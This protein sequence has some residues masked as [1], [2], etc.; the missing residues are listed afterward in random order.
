MEYPSLDRRRQIALPMRLAP[1]VT[2]TVP[3]AM[4][5]RRQHLILPVVSAHA[6]RSCIA[7]WLM[8]VLHPTVRWHLASLPSTGIQ[9]LQE[10]VEESPD[11]V[12]LSE[13]RRCESGC[14]HGSRPRCQ[15]VTLRSDTTKPV[16]AF[17]NMVC[18]QY[19]RRLA[20]L[21]ST[22]AGAGERPLSW[23]QEKSAPEGAD[24][25][26]LGLRKFLLL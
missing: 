19:A 23:W 4:L 15:P 20:A 17:M 14:L 7:E 16:Q 21:M 24:S 10:V 1:P 18:T 25:V 9:S 2:N 26:P 12:L 3:S 22:I 8:S 5:G 11:R 6:G 13:E